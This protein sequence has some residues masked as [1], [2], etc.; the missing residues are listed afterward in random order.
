MLIFVDFNNYSLHMGWELV[1]PLVVRLGNFSQIDDDIN[2]N[3]NIN[4]DG[5]TTHALQKSY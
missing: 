3:N 1:F 5:P 4:A 2:D